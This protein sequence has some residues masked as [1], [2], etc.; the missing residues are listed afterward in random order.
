MMGWVKSLCSLS[1][2][3]CKYTLQYASIDPL[4]STQ[5]N[6]MINLFEKV[7][8][9]VVYVSTLLEA[10]NPMS[11]NVM[12]ISSQTGSGFVWDSN[13][14]IVTNYHVLGPTKS[15]VQITFLNDDGSRNARRAKVRGVD[16][17]KDIAVLKLIEESDVQKNKQE[18]QPIALGSSKNLR[19]GQFAIAIGNPFG[20]DQTLTTGI[21]SGLGRQVAS[22]SKKPIYNMIQTDAAINPGNSGGPLLDSSGAVIG[23]N[24]AIYSTSGAS[25]GIGFAIPID[26]MKAVVEIIIRDGRVTRPNT[27][28]RFYTG[29][30]QARSLGVE[31]GLVVVDVVAGSAAAVA[32]I[33]GISRISFGSIK[34]GDTIIEV[35]SM[36][37]DT[38]ADF[39]KAID[40]NVIGD[41]IEMTVMRYIEDT[42]GGAVVNGV[43]GAFI[44][45]KF[46][47]NTN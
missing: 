33:R 37:C 5:E 21:V 28:I 12:E 9:S 1:K 23:M 2:S 27:G 8:P 22:P 13:G 39:L 29:P 26:T 47:S 43:K 16:I 3:R 35:N 30:N 6:A 45:L 40:G 44:S 19:V 25:A 36:R 31:R 42:K 11:M 32:G 4:L 10:F 18:I 41:T 17:D 7:R 20:L 34:L 24:T 14:H 38:E 46:S 15:E